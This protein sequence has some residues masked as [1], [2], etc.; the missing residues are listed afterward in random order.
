MGVEIISISR[1][2]F[3]LEATSFRVG[4]LM[5]ESKIDQNYNEGLI[6]IKIH[7]NGVYFNYDAVVC[8]VRIKVLR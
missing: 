7:V 4:L 3:N 8:H 6:T 1:G 2:I 5:K